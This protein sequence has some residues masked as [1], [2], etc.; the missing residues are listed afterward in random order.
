MDRRATRA[1]CFYDWAN[2]AFATTVM[3]ALFPP[4]FREL[5]IAAGRGSAEATALWGYVTAGALLLIAITAPLLGAVAD[6]VGGRKRFMAFLA[7]L[8]VLATGLFAT[9]G[10]EGW[11]TAAVLYVAANFGFAGS[12]IFYESLLPGLASG[13]DMDR[14]SAQ[15]YGLGY[16]GGGLLLVIN[17]LWVMH[18]DWFAMPDRGFAVRA[19]FVSVAVWW[20]LFSLPL[21]KFVPEPPITSNGPGAAPGSVLTLG[22]RRL[23]TTMREITRYRQLVVFLVAYWIYNDGIGTIVK[24]ATAYGAE[25]GIGMTDLIGALVL[26]QAVGIPFAVLFGRL[27][28]RTGPKPAV[29]LALAVYLVISVFGFFLNT[30][31][32]FYVLAGLV[33]TVQGGAQALS[34]SLFAA[35][36]PRHR[37]GE[38]FGFYSSSGKLAGVAGPLVFGLVSQGTGTSR[39]G[40][41]SLVVFF[42]VGGWLLTRVDVAAGEAA[43]RRAEAEAGFQDPGNS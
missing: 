3:A 30:A 32:Q 26:T 34:R 19:S 13:R 10:T 23:M 18:P 15:A 36:V 2:S 29:L 16:A 42:A 41:L 25:I 11:R 21:F 7:G 24:M 20:G 38:F 5:A 4:F 27:A 28:R 31:T 1:W 35:M 39:L 37:T 43:A 12:I 9:L 17:L 40:I 8:G 6:V 33:G 14:L 22:F